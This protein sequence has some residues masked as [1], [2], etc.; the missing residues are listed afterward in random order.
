MGCSKEVFLKLWVAKLP[1]Y[2][3]KKKGVGGEAELVYCCSGVDEQKEQV[4]AKHCAGTQGS[5]V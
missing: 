2:L 3:E 1:G 5:D 4:A